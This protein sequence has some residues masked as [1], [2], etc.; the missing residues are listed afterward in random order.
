MYVAVE[1]FVV[2]VPV[3]YIILLCLPLLVWKCRIICSLSMSNQLITTVN[4]RNYPKCQAHPRHPG[5]YWCEQCPF[6]NCPCHSTHEYGNHCAYCVNGIFK[7]TSDQAVARSARLRDT[8]SPHPTSSC[9]HAAHGNSNSVAGTSRPVLGATDPL[10]RLRGRTERNTP[11]AGEFY[12][13]VTSEGY[14]LILQT[15]SGESCVI[16][17]TGLQTGEFCWRGLAKLYGDK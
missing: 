9:W 11:V 12:C 7:S 15:F 2:S 3:L 10:H 8:Q 14:N 13:A 6:C 5:N 16:E 4:G 1:L 17:L